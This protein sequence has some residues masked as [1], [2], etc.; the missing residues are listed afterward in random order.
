MLNEVMFKKFTEALHRKLE[1]GSKTYGEAS[2]KRPQKEIIE[3]IQEEL[4]DVSG[5]SWIL[6]SR[7]EAL[8]EQNNDKY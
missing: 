7:L 2:F 5:W 3:E 4:V 1:A 8:K 6:W